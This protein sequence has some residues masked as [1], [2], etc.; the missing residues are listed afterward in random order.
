[1]GPV[2]DSS[3]KISAKCDSAKPFALAEPLFRL[4]RRFQGREGLSRQ[5][6]FLQTFQ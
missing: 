6:E 5:L 1:M 3:L 2:T 4:Y